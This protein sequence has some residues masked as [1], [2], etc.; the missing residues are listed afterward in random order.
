MGSPFRAKGRKFEMLK[1]LF[2]EW[3]R[4]CFGQF[5]ILLTQN[6]QNVLNELRV[7]DEFATG[8]KPTS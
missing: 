6:V 3:R 8:F 4:S 5:R 7:D 2:T 1:S